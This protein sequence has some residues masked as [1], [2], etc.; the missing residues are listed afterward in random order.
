MRLWIVGQTRSGEFP[1]LVWDFQ[2]V[3]DSEDKARE[4]CINE[5]YWM[6]PITVNESLSDE[7]YAFPDIVYPVG[8]SSR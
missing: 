1:D 3:F 4:A 6:A 5:W 8:I 7:S 2:G